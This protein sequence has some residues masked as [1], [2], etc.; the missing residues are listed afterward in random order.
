MTARPSVRSRCRRQAGAARRSDAC[1]GAWRRP[2][3]WPAS[4]S[5]SSASAAVSRGAR[6]PEAFWRLLRDGV[7]AVTEIP[8]E[9]WDLDA[10]YDA[11]PDAAGRMYTRHGGFVERRRPVR[12]GVLRHLAAR[13]EQH[14]PAAAPA[15]RGG[16]GGARARRPGPGAPGRQRRPA[17]SSASATSDYAHL[18]LRPA[19]S[20]PIDPYFA[21]GTAHSV[22]RRAGCPTCSACSG[23][24]VAVDTACSSSLVAVHL[25][26]QSL[27]AGECDLALAGGVNL[28]P[29]ARAAPS[30][31]AGRAML[32]PDGRCKTFDAAADGYVRGE[33]VRRGR[34]QAAVATRWPTATASSP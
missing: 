8:A 21:T 14:G 15:A 23:P 27:R 13:G 28:D 6:D 4:P 20:T 7:D 32:A 5:P 10:Y 2:S 25:A 16:L 1:A 11:D 34:A 31:S 26:C 29:L 22:A 30:T 18:L 9:R 33:G 3:G 24:D 17:S 19:R 12:P